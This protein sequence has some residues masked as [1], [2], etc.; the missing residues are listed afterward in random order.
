[1]V[2]SSSTAAT[3]FVLRHVVNPGHMLVPDALN[4]V[5]AEAN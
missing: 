5:T 1:M 4:A 3:A 2:C